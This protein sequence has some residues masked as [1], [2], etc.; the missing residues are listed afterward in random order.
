MA[1]TCRAYYTTYNNG[2]TFQTNRKNS[3][4]FA[5]SV[6]NVWF[7]H[8]SDSCCANVWVS[9]LMVD[10]VRA[11]VCVKYILI[12]S[13][14][15]FRLIRCFCVLFHSLCVSNHDILSTL[16][17]RHHFTLRDL[18]VLLLFVLSFTLQ[19][20][21]FDMQSSFSIDRVGILSIANKS[22]KRWNDTKWT[23]QNNSRTHMYL[24]IER[25]V[26]IYR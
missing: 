25:F 3:H 1:R 22:Y 6:F 21:S 14:S 20:L 8:F 10:C 15:F 4:C 17:F 2:Q 19:L 24:E 16:C 12:H 11:C 7:L 26:Q 9:G 18:W 23:I 13:S 5:H